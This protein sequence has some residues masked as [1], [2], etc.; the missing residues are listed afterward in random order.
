VGYI[1]NIHLTGHAFWYD[2]LMCVQ[3]LQFSPSMFSD[4]TAFKTNIPLFLRKTFYLLSQTSL[5]H[6]MILFGSNF[7]PLLVAPF[8]FSST[9]QSVPQ[10]TISKPSLGCYFL[11]HV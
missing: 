6:L 10:H 4:H 1:K 11:L 9:V 7:L 2:Q 8:V 5:S 3:Q